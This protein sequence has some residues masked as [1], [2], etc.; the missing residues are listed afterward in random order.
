MLLHHYR[1]APEFELFDF[2]DFAR[3]LEGQRSPIA[4]FKGALKEIQSRLDERF[5]GGADIR[6][7]VPASQLAGE[8]NILSTTSNSLRQLAIFNRNI[9]AVSIFINNNRLHFCRCHRINCKAC[10][11]FIPEDDI[12]T[13]TSQFI[14]H[15]L[16]P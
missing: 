14:G 7:L 5:L 12:N 10:H 16:N 1:F 2:D 9:H 13:F 8:A 3:Q 15:S 4:P 11:I 6:D